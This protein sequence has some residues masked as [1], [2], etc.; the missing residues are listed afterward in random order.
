M[1]L[2]TTSH[3]RYD[4]KYHFVW[5]PK[6]RRLALKGNVGK[7]VAKIIYEVAERYDFS[8]IE[9]AVQPDHVHL[10]ISALPDDSPAV[11]I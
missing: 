1:V 9:L 2:E 6:Y 11:L 4:L 8:V 10:F 5:C 7:Y 3:A